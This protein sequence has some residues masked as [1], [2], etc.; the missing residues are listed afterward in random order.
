MPLTAQAVL[1]P[2][3][4]PL[5]RFKDLSFHYDDGTELIFDHLSFDLP[6]LEQVCVI[7]RTGAGKTTFFRLSL[8]LLEPT[9][10]ALLLNGYPVQAKSPMP[11]SVIS[12]AMSSKVLNLCPELKGSNQFRR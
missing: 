9:S 10:G 6:A 1:K 12:L 2:K 8:G 11:K 5:L 7:G 4:T 3:R